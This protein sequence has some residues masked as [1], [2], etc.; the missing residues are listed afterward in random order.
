MSFPKFIKNTLKGAL[1]LPLM[2]IGALLLYFILT[3]INKAYWN[4]WVINMCSKEKLVTVFETMDLDD[5][6]YRSLKLGLTG[7]PYLPF[8]STRDKSDPIYWKT[9]QDEKLRFAGLVTT[10]FVSEI[11]RAS[12]NKVMSKGINYSRSGGDFTTLGSPGTAFSCNDVVQDGFEQE[13]A[14]FGLN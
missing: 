2:V 7:L 6:A 8:D 3:E 1:L 14:T 10:I 13:K 12:D 11:I 5:P 4:N 9:T